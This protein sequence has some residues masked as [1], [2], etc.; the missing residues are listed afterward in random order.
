VI[1]HVEVEGEEYTLR[2]GDGEAF[3][4]SYL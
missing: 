3:C 1:K 2:Y 4:E